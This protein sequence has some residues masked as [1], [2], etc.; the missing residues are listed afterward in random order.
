MPDLALCIWWLHHVS[1]TRMA[2]LQQLFMTHLHAYLEFSVTVAVM[3]FWNLLSTDRNT[4]GDLLHQL[5]SCV[6]C[7]CLWFCIKP[8]SYKH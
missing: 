7:V 2:A 5:L 1:S 6:L 8:Q 3:L 4:E